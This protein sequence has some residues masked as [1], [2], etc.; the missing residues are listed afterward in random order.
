MREMQNIF[1]DVH[2]VCHTT[3]L[4]G[5]C[6]VRRIRCSLC[7]ITSASCYFAYCTHFPLLLTA[8]PIAVLSNRLVIISYLYVSLCD[9]TEL[10]ESAYK[11]QLL[12]LNLLRLLAQNKLGDFHTVPV[13]LLTA[14]FH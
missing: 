10:Q 5:A 8:L 9:S 12:G 14:V 13:T 6:S 3:Q 7:Q 11:Y 1:T 4:S 2:G